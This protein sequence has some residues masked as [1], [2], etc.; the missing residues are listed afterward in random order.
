MIVK[1][2]FATH[3]LYFF[4]SSA[5]LYLMPVVVAWSLRNRLCSV[6]A[7]RSKINSN[8]HLNVI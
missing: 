6:L 3:A 7:V 4:T 2:V 8:D 1:S 5:I